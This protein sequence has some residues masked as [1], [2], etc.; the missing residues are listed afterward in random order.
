MC[1][2]LPE[3]A[4]PYMKRLENIAI[5]ALGERKHALESIRSF[6]GGMIDVDAS[7]FFEAVN[8]KEKPYACIACQL[9]CVQLNLY[10]DSR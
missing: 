10:G 2:V 7:A 8:E 3:V 5:C 4:T 9:Y 1:D 6:W